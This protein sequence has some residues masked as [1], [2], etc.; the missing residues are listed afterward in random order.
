MN[1][2]FTTIDWLI[3]TFKKCEKIH[4]RTRDTIATFKRLISEEINADAEIDLVLNLLDIKDTDYY[5]D[6]LNSNLM[7]YTLIS[8]ELIQ[9]KSN[10]ESL[11]I[12]NAYKDKGILNNKVENILKQAFN[13]EVA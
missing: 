6:S 3:D 10:K 8:K 5:N 13:V 2:S 11:N 7:Q 4:G 9:S 12:I 1:I